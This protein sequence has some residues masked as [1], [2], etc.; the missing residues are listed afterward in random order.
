LKTDLL[1]RT[2][3]GSEDLVEA[4]ESALLLALSILAYNLMAVMDHRHSLA[5]IVG[6]GTSRV[7]ADGSGKAVSLLFASL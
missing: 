1:G 3:K 5:Q 6:G 7:L 2:C 4:V